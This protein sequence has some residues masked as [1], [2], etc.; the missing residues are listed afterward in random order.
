MKNFVV[1][2]S[3]KK[4]ME[5]MKNSYFEFFFK[6]CLEICERREKSLWKIQMKRLLFIKKKK[7]KEEEEEEEVV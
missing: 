3:K 4:R 7:K 6:K 1:G 5:N 2:R